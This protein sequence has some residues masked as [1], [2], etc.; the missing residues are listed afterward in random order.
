MKIR[1]LENTKNTKINEYVIQGR[2]KELYAIQL[3]I[4]KIYTGTIYM[5]L[6]GFQKC[7]QKG[8][9]NTSINDI[10]NFCNE[11]DS[12]LE[13]ILDENIQYVLD[14]FAIIFCTENDTFETTK[15]N[16]Y[17]I[18]YDMEELIICLISSNVSRELTNTFLKTEI[19]GSEEK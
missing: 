18:G 11:K 3:N 10:I 9:L 12:F 2:N 4:E 1:K 19:K 13:K 16:F 8:I 15:R 7:F 5:C 17:K 6:K 14:S